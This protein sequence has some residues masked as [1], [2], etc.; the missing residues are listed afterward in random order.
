MNRFTVA[1]VSHRGWDRRKVGVFIK[2]TVTD[3]CD[4]GNVLYLDC[5]KVNIQVV[6]L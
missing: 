5:V 2:V 1:G 6:T 4:D 3:P